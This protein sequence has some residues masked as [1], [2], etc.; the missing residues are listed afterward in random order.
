MSSGCRVQVLRN[1][2]TFVIILRKINMNLCTWGIY[3]EGCHGGSWNFSEV[4]LT[5]KIPEL[6]KTSSNSGL[7]VSPGRLVRL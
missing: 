3:S 1:E 6:N 2:L 4:Q 5:G 7:R